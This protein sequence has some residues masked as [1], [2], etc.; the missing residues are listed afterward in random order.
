M[1]AGLGAVLPLRSEATPGAALT[2]LGKGGKCGSQSFDLAVCI[3]SH[4]VPCVTY[5]P[6]GNASGSPSAYGESSHGA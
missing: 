5:S 4:K 6:A 3:E 2:L 1:R